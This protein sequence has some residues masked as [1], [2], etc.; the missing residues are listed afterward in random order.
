MSIGVLG[1]VLAILAL[2]G[3]SYA[4]IQGPQAGWGST[5]VRS[6][7]A[8]AA[9][10]L[11]ALVRRERRTQKPVLAWELF[12][13]MPFLGA[14]LIG[15]LFNF[16]LYGTLFMLG[17]FLQ[18]ARG[19]SPFVAGLELLPMTI[20]FPLSNVVFSRLGGRVA[21]GL[22][23]IGC[24]ALAAIGSLAMVTISPRTPYWV[25]ALAVGIANV[26]AGI[27]SPAMTAVLVDSAG[28]EHANA[29]GAVL[30]ANRQIGSLIGVAGVGVVLDTTGDWYSGAA[31]TFLMVGL[32]YLVA[33]VIAAATIWRHETHASVETGCNHAA[34]RENQVK[35]IARG[36]MSNQYDGVTSPPKQVK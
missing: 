27:I 21:N 14:N 8:V 36:V 16:S 35:P 17:L 15:F 2:A 3:F 25:L 24:L 6:A 28:P 34:E 33:I 5:A 23:L 32:I 26:G 29:S 7:V 20:F 10:A 19:A 22:L 18:N 30:T 12:K 31:R 4:L 13:S 9:L 1:H 11:I